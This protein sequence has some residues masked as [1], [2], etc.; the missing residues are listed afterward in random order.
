MLDPKK[1]ELGEYNGISYLLDR[2]SHS[3]ASKGYDLL[4]YLMKLLESRIN[5]LIKT[6]HRTIDGYNK[7]AKEKWPHIFIFVDEGCDIIRI[8]DSLNVLS[9]ILE[10]GNRCG[11]HLVYATNSYLKDY[12]NS[13]FLDMF[14]YRMTFDLASM[15]QEEFIDIKGSSWLKTDGEALIKEP[16]GNIYKF[17]APYVKDDEINDVVLK[18]KD[19]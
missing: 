3:D 6:N 7:D 11:F 2:K 15:E 17:C 19:K 10:F 14:K 4:I 9:K 1:I 12:S 18:S 5:T 13:K 16:N 8:K